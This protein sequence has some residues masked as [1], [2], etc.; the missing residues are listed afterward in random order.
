[1]LASPQQG[2]DGGDFISF[3]PSSS[4]KANLIADNH[5]S[6]HYR[7]VKNTHRE[8]LLLVG[9]YGF[10]DCAVSHVFRVIPLS[11]S[12]AVWR[13][14][15]LVCLILGAS[16]PARGA[17]PRQQLWREGEGESPDWSRAHHTAP[18]PTECLAV[19]IAARQFR[20]LFYTRAA[21]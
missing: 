8:K 1:M 2:T 18:A 5:A 19:S 13:E 6:L 10:D 11:L 14:V 12:E 20:K 7:E 9:C 15:S 16:L 3:L 17:A 4:K 21:N